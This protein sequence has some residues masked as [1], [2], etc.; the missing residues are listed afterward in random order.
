[1]MLPSAVSL[2]CR[3]SAQESR[4]THT[5]DKAACR[6]TSAIIVENVSFE[7]LAQQHIQFEIPKRAKSMVESKGSSYSDPLLRVVEHGDPSEAFRTRLKPAWGAMVVF[8]DSTRRAELSSSHPVFHCPH[9]VHSLQFGDLYSV[10]VQPDAPLCKAGLACFAFTTL[11][12]R[13]ELS[14]QICDTVCSDLGFFGTEYNGCVELC[15]F[16][17]SR[18]CLAA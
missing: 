14:L 3:L 12:P 4:T 15:S 9:P 8:C 16:G 18:E 10:L 6:T 1:M 2:T 5:C 11:R 13:R 7:Q 17:D